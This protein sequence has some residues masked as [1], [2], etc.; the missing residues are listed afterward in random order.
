LNG[1]EVGKIFATYTHSLGAV[2]PNV[3]IIYCNY[4]LGESIG[5]GSRE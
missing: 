4:G 5:W 2:T 3:I 1:H